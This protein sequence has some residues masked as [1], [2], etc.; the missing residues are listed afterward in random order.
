MRT[1]INWNDVYRSS[2]LS[3]ADLGKKC[4]VVQGCFEL[5]MRQPAK[6]YLPE[7][8]VFDTWEESVTPKNNTKTGFGAKIPTAYIIKCTDGRSRRVYVEHLSKSPDIRRGFII[9]SD[10]KLKV[11][12]W[13]PAH[14]AD[15][16]IFPSAWEPTITKDWGQSPVM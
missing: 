14:P 5:S 1:S 6:Q 12:L 8:F 13:F 10:Q 11:K 16:Y 2:T 15:G 3:R 4:Q 9:V 7:D